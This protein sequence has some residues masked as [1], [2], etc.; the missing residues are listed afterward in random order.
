MANVDV[1]FENDFEDRKKR[2]AEVLRQAEDARTKDI[3]VEGDS[4]STYF[5]GV[6][7]AMGL[8]MGTKTGGGKPSDPS[9]K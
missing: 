8:G 7:R 1:D 6:V 3:K 4:I 9:P 2:A 5:W